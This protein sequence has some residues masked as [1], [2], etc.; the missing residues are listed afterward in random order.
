MNK[1]NINIGSNKT[2]KSDRVLPVLKTVLTSKPEIR[3][4]YL[5]GSLATNTANALSDIDVA[6]FIDP[7]YKH[8]SRGFGYQSELI[9]ELSSLTSHPVDLVI[10][11]KAPTL[12]KHRIISNGILIFSRSD[13]ERREFHETTNRNY[14][15]LKPIY[16]VQQE[17]LRKRLQ[18]A[19]CGGGTSG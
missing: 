17:Y 19:N 16:K 8:S 1:V 14:L 9:E 5:F 13:A 3:F 2:L 6:V 10:L 18:K 12:L 15:D 4:A 11:N 7:S